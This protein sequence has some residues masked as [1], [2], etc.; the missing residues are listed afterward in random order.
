MVRA[1]RPENSFRNCAQL[2]SEEDVARKASRSAQ[3][4]AVDRCAHETVFE[5]LCEH[6]AIVDQR[7]GESHTARCGSNATRCCPRAHAALA[8]CFEWRNGSRRNCRSSS[9]CLKLPREL[10]VLRVI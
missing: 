6:D 8:G 2:M 3:G 1:R 10:A 7:A 4:K 9:Q 5:R